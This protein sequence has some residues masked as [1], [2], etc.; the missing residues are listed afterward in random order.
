MGVS[1]SR[2]RC[3]GAHWAGACSIGRCERF[4][5]IALTMIAPHLN[6]LP[7]GEENV[8]RQVSVK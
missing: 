5:E 1:R 6:P 3:R 4:N 2:G 8:K 7:E